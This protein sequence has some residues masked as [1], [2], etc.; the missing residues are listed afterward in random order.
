MKPPLT[1]FPDA[2]LVIEA[3]DKIRKWES[4]V[5]LAFGNPLL[6]ICVQTPE[7]QNICQEFGISPDGESE[8]PAAVNQQ[9][10]ERIRRWV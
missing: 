7:N 8:V 9:L 3:M 10:Q 6:D 5:L 4:P 2:S 1:S